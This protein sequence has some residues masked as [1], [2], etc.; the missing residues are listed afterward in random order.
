[1]QKIE[2]DSSYWIRYRIEDEVES[3]ITTEEISYL[4]CYICEVTDK[5]GNT[6]DVTFNL[7]VENGLVVSTPVPFVDPTEEDV[8]V[9]MNTSAELSVVAQATNTNGL[10]YQWYQYAYD[11]EYGWGWAAIENATSSTYQTDVI[12]EGTKYYC[13]VVD[14][15]GNSGHVQYNVHIDNGFS[16]WIAGSEEHETSCDMGVEVG[17][18]AVLA[19]EATAKDPAGITYQ[20]YC[21]LYDPDYG[22]SYSV[23]LEGETSDT[24][25]TGE[26]SNATVYY[27]AVEDQYGNNVSVYFY[28][29]IDTGLSA[30]AKGSEEHREFV[31]VWV[32]PNTTTTFSVEATSNVPEEITYQW[33]CEQ[34]DTENE[35]WLG[36]IVEGETTDT[37][38][39]DMIPELTDYYCRQNGGRRSARSGA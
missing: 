39:P 24:Y 6:C 17:S 26:I 11:E 29:Y 4:T 33:Y 36:V 18:A 14:R 30:W 3:S 35:C 37:Y 20:W 19:V 8:F 13:L 31:E 12:T 7:S 21:D 16:A 25:T 38:T 32:K 28:L 27:C 5:Y 34:Y 15:Y 23:T 2:A 1:M 10:Y 22:C 9:D